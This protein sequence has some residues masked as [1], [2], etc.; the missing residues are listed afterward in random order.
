VALAWLPVDLRIQR[1]PS[2]RDDLEVPMTSSTHNRSP[3]RRRELRQAD[4]TRLV[5]R[6]DGTIVALDAAGAVARTWPEGDPEWADQAI[7]FG[8]RPRPETVKPGP[9]DPMPQPTPR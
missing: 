8:V 9:P 7:R 1:L 4:G 2:V 6:T 5:L 3:F